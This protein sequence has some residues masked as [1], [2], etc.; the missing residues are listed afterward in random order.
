M[1]GCHQARAELESGLGASTL[2]FES[3]ILRCADKKRSRTPL[4]EIE[5]ME[6]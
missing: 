3:R 2:G 5:Q 1:D 6:P 4:F